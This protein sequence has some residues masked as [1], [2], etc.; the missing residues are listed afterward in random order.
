MADSS[1]RVRQDLAQAFAADD[2]QQ[3]L[4]IFS[5]ACAAA[6]ANPEPAHA[7]PSSPHPEDGSDARAGVDNDSADEGLSAAAPAAS[8]EGGAADAAQEMIFLGPATDACEAVSASAL[9]AGAEHPPT[10][11]QLAGLSAAEPHLAAPVSMPGQMDALEGFIGKPKCRR[12]IVEI[13]DITAKG[14]RVCGKSPPKFTWPQCCTKQT[15]PTRLYGR[16]PVPEFAGL[17]PSEKE[18]FF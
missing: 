10:G 16:W 5:R 3:T 14:I 18:E 8:G 11:P 4:D 1:K 2:R 15:T 12:C 6:A 9:V 13:D 17:T 7:V